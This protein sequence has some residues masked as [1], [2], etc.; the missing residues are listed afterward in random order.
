MNDTRSSEEGQPVSSQSAAK[1]LSKDRVSPTAP[2]KGVIKEIK[3]QN[4]PEVKDFKERCGVRGEIPLQKQANEWKLMRCKHYNK[5]CKCEILDVS[6][7]LPRHA[8]YV[9][10]NNFY[11]AFSS[12]YNSHNDLQLAPDDVWMQIQLQ[13][14]D[15]VNGPGRA[16]KL[17]P[18]FVSHQGKQKLSVTTWNETSESQW[19]EFFSLMQQQ[20]SKS[21][22]DGVVGKLTCDFSTTG[23]V[24]R[25]LSCAAI[26]DSF[27]QYFSYGRCIP[28]CGV[29]NVYLEGTL[30][31]W[32]SII[33]KLKELR[34][35]DMDG[36]WDNYVQNLLP[37]L[38]KLAETYQG[39]VDLDWWNKMMNIKRGRLGSG[40]TSYVSGWILTFFGLAGKAQV[41]VADIVGK[42]IE[43]DVTIDNKQTGYTKTVQVLGGFGGV[44]VRPT[45]G[46]R[47]AFRPQMS[48]AVYW[49]GRQ[50]STESDS[51]GEEVRP[52]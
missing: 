21:T 47:C 20:I 45:P 48:L 5:A 3:L 23:P 29:R 26:M 19:G 7:N 18:N 36:V 27:K 32:V 39:K 13:F 42:T 2:S 17:R 43:V 12:A 14:T 46:G 34:K 4:L 6:A 16:E 50:S 49:D 22:K 25:A 15:Y 31:D 33:T 35:Y 10:A 8:G 51:R 37:V 30:E 9:S 1:Y 28:C 52:K 11:E 41:D 40:S 44:Y 38:N 24:E